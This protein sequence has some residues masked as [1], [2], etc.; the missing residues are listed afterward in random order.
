MDT[1]SPTLITSTKEQCTRENH[2]YMPIPHTEEGN[3]RFIHINTGGINPRA[4]YTEFKLL[5]QN[6]KETQT[7]V[8][9]VNEHC[10]DTSQD[11]IRKDLYDVGKHT[12]KYSTQFFSTSSEKFP[13]AY[14]PGGTMIGLDG[15]IVGRKGNT[16]SRQ[17]W[18][19]DLGSTN[20]EEREEDIGYTCI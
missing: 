3:V 4:N 5:L 1:N 13:R 17:Q 11:Q 7:A 9:S 19:V 20:G 10:M 18:E 16:W 12:C 8:Y 15:K 6:I 14:K 2:R